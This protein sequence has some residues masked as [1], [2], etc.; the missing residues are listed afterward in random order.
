M[1]AV[2]IMAGLVERFQTV[3]GL[4]VLDYEPTTIEPPTLYTLLDGFERSQQGQLTV[5]RYR[6]MSRLCIRWQDNEYAER[7]LLPFVNA[8]PAA[9]DADP[10]LGG[11]ISSGL[12]RVVSAAGDAQRPL[13]R[14]G[15]VDYRAVDFFSDVLHKFPYRSGD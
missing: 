7:E 13:V 12:A 8:I 2:T 14:I 1:S 11:R 5:M 6:F 10:Q 15:N 4:I 9:V 3:S